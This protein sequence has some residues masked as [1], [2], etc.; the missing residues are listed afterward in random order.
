[1]S[2]ST[3]PKDL[4]VLMQWIYLSFVHPRFNREAHDSFME[5]LRA[6]VQNLRNDPQTIMGDSLDLIMTDYNPR[7]RIFDN[8][9]LDDV[10]FEWIE[11]VYRDRFADASDFF[12]VIVGNMEADSVKPLV[13]KYIGAIPDLDRSEYWIDRKIRQ[14]EG[15]VR[16]TIPMAMETPKANVNI[17]INQSMEYNPFHR[18]TMEVIEGILDL[19]YVESI[20]EEEGGT[21]GV[22][23]GAGLRRWPVEK[24]ILRIAFDCDPGRVEDLKEKVYQELDKLMEEGPTAQDLSKTVENLLK[25][26]EERRQHNSYYMDAIYSKYV[27]GI[28]LFAAENYEEILRDL[29]VKDVRKVMKA[30]YKKP[31]IVDVVFVPLEEDAATP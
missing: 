3:T 12:F 26:R 8:E 5:R 16:K 17:V 27:H 19:R 2:G 15:V 28:D 25:N 14:P 10:S 4:E 6:Y 24:G 23:V 21:Y 7:T 31:D 11:S 29:T 22:S 13:Q 18:V 9:F 20:R 30:L 1:L